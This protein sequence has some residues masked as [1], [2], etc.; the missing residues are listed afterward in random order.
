M[1]QVSG[2]KYYTPAQI[3]KMANELHF[4]PQR[5]QQTR[6]INLWNKWLVLLLFIGLL[7]VE[8]SIRRR[9]GML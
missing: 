3:E 2:G 9:K 1:A 5:L 6:E 4:P 7:V 8:W